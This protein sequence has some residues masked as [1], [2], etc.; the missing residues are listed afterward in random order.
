MSGA[1]STIHPDSSTARLSSDWH[2][3]FREPLQEHGFQS[4]EVQGAVPEGLSGTLFRNGPSQFQLFDTAYQHWFD[5]DGAVS[6]TRFHAGQAQGAI[7][8]VQTPEL[9]EEK[10]AG[11]QLYSIYATNSPHWSWR[12]GRKFKNVANTSVLQWQGKLYALCE[13]GKPTQLS[14]ED[15]S[16]LGQ[17]DL[18]GCVLESFSAHPHRVASR[19]S[20]LNFGVRY[21]S[22]TWVDL[23]E[24]P[25]Q[26]AAR[27]LASHQLPGAPMVHDF[28]ATEKHAVF[29]ISPVRT[30]QLK[31]L[32]GMGS[33]C[34]NLAWKP[35][36]GTEI[37]VMP[38]DR[39]QEIRRFQTEAFYQWHF[40]NAYEDRGEIVVDFIRYEDFESNEW[41]RQIVTGKLKS[42]PVGRYSRAR[43]NPAQKSFSCET[44]WEQP[45]EFPRISPHREGAVHQWAWMAAHLPAEAGLQGPHNGLARL[46]LPTAEVQAFELPEGQHCSE[47]VF[48]PRPDSQTEDDGWILTQVY[49]SNQARTYIGIWDGRNWQPEPLAKVWYSSFLPYSF[50]GIWNGA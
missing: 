28:I 10:R 37:L 5:G 12:V 34:D 11:K 43:L 23:Y 13:A 15:L 25:D 32:L 42:T 20:V 3:P 8:Q 44:L 16:T 38:L 39:P 36:L 4:L 45:C 31:M 47:P 1:Q 29:F 18:E 2:R 30:N 6:A 7:R 50:H 35:E 9:L 27:H 24:L 49:D 21:E 41:A 40:A 33:F 48:V 26:G 46:H 19:K 22:K 17:R 14:L